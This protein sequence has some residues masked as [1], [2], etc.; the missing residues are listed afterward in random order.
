M[1]GTYGGKL[2]EN[3]VQAAARDLLAVKMLDLHEMGYRIVMHV[4]DEVVIEVKNDRHAQAHLKEVL[5]VMSAPVDW[6]PGLTLNAD[7]YL[8]EY[9]QKD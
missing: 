8:C 5:A 7:G 6:A 1:K 2:V 4:H 3:I 9:Y